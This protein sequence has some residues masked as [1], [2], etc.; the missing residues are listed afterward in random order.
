M[1]ESK[2]TQEEDRL[3]LASLE[4]A[5]DDVVSDMG[6]GVKFL[7][8]PVEEWAGPGYAIGA[9]FDPYV[10]TARL[11]SSRIILDYSP[12]AMEDGIRVLETRCP[13]KEK[14]TFDVHATRSPV[15][16]LP[17]LWGGVN[18]HRLAVKEDWRAVAEI[19]EQPALVV[20][21][22]VAVF[23]FNPLRVLHRYLCMAFPDTTR[24]LTDLMVMAI[25]GASG[26]GLDLDDHDLRRDFHALGVN[27]LLVAQ[28]Y[29]VAGRRWDIREICGSLEHA[30]ALYRAGDHDAAR[31]GLA[32]LFRLLEE[33]R[34]AIVATPIHIMVMPHGG[35][36]F[37]DEGYAEYDW[38]EAAARVLNLYLDWG[39][40]FGFK[41]APDIGAGTLE[42]FVKLHPRTVQRLGEAWSQ[43]RIE[44]VNGSYSQPYMQ[45]FPEWDQNKQFEVGL[46]TFES[47]F[48]RRPTVYAAQEMAL[49]PGLPALLIKHGYRHAVHRCQNLGRAPIDSAPLIDWRT[50]SGDAGIRALPAHALRTERRGGETWRH[51]PVLLASAK[52]EGLP[53]IAIT[54]LMDQ[55]FIDIYNEEILRANHY[56]P[57]WGGFVIP[58]EFFGKTEDVA[59]VAR[60]YSL[61]QYHYDLEL[62]GNLIHGHQ[63]GGYSSE[64]AFMLKE[65]VRLQELEKQG[66]LPAAD[67]KTLL[68][69]EAHDCYIIPYFTPGYFMESALTDYAGPRYRCA[70]DKPRGIDRCIRDAAGYPVTFSDVATVIPEPCVS[71]GATLCHQGVV[72]EIDP[73]TAAVVRIAGQRVSLGKLM[74]NGEPFRSGPPQMLKGGHGLRVAGRL[75]GFGEMVVDYFACGGWFYGQIKAVSTIPHWNDTRTTWADC[76]YLEHTKP[77]GASV[78]RTVSNVTQPTALERFHSLDRL[79]IQAAGRVWSLRHG[80]NIFFRQTPDTV[81]NR[82]WCYNE[83]CDTFHWGVA[84]TQP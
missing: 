64:H 74:Y 68:N 50:P 23:A 45:L 33:R 82:L 8:L 31:S 46:K 38:P 12:S 43:G 77:P 24:D 11:Q 56:A 71:D 6:R 75:P 39:E 35:I 62:S 15:L 16:Y 14:I 32:S 48:S 69:Q 47:L 70:S 65:S 13:Q 80:G 37:P 25:L 19:S 58:S 41:F 53:F 26:I 5:L 63:T 29:R 1:E 57:V 9:L 81:R 42:E 17:T 49:H 66:R 22:G 67:L 51:F 54:S 21:P 72:V 27:V 30:A 73:A 83:F 28:L 34:K 40:R 2:T 76:V 52:N 79:A 61:D 36:L 10:L 20:R 78:L 7:G 60:R 59:A 3:F 84:L 18:Y 4:S 44:F 55:T